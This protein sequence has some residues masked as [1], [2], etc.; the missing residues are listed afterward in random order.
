[1]NMHKWLL[2]NFDASCLYV[3]KRKDLIDTFSITP[4]FLRNPQSDSGLVTDYRDWQIPLGRRFRSLKIWFVLRTYGVQGMQAHIRN[5]IQL[6][7][8]FG[9]WVASRSDLFTIISG[10]TFALTVLT[11]NPAPKPVSVPSEDGTPASLK[12]HPSAKDDD[13][14]ESNNLTRQVYES[15]NGE[16]RIMLTSCVLGAKYA[17][18]VV[19]ANPKADETHLRRAFGI[20]V[21][22]AERVRGK[23]LGAVNGHV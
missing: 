12:V 13:E 10:P 18:R 9:T 1:M 6:G 3:K 21:L 20:L 5:H 7:E 8:K 16:G 4:S 15:V 23:G 17:I 19:S 22:A 2:T 14:T 11:I